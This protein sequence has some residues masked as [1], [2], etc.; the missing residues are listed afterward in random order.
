M[1]A[2]TAA[3]AVA[4]AL[5]THTCQEGYCLAYTRT[6]LDIAPVSPDAKDAWDKCINKHPGDRNPPRG[7]WVY[8]SGGSEDH[9]HAALSLGW[10]KIR[11]TDEMDSGEVATVDLEYIEE[12]WGLEYEGWGEDLNGVPI[13]FL[14]PNPF[15]SG[16]VYVSKLHYNQMDSDSVSRLRWRL[17]HHDR[18]PD[19]L[20]PGYGNDYGPKVKAAVNYIQN[21][22][23]P[24]IHGP[25][26]GTELSN[27]QA[28]A[29]FGSTY[30]VIEA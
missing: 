8:Y 6:W 24:Q 26:D 25:H 3:V 18:L 12:D 16:L 20:R 30:E 28:N 11:S 22:V 15:A 23:M 14:G 5:A 13:P 17:M 2:Q 7:A 1:V 10:G 21:K 29:L 4:R 27:P 19:E 9:G